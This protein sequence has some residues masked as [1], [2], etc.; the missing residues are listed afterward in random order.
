MKAYQD[1]VYS[2]A[3][4]LLGNDAHA[5]DISQEVFLKAYQRF[6]DVA[7]SPTAGGWL[8]TVTRNLALNHLSRYRRRFRL[9]SEFPTSED[10]ETTLPEPE[11]LD[12]VLEGL[13]DHARYARIEAALARLPERQ[14]VPLVLFHF[15]ELSYQQIA[16]MLGSTL[17]KVKTDIHRGRLALATSLVDE[18]GALS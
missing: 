4:R 17:A 2:T 7:A 18:R 10:G 9:F 15:E 16:A 1:M 8:K 12:A 3:R 11:H 5:R 6:E 14:R 13:D